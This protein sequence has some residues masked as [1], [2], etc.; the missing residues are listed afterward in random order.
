MKLGNKKYTV[1]PEIVMVI[2]GFIGQKQLNLITIGS[3]VYNSK[4]SRIREDLF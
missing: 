1:Y 2:I 4:Q 3:V